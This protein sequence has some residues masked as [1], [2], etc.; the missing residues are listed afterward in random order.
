MRFEPEATA[1]L[2]TLCRKYAD[3]PMS[4][5]DACLVHLSERQPR[6]RLVSFDSDFQVYRRH[7]SERILVLRPP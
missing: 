1:A 7:G 6:A 4:W 2:T 5:A 3:V